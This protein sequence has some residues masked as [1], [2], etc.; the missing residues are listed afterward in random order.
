MGEQTHVEVGEEPSDE[1]TGKCPARN[2]V[3][4]DNSHTPHFEEQPEGMGVFYV[5]RCSTCGTVFETWDTEDEYLDEFGS[6]DGSNE[7]TA[8]FGD[9]F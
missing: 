4:H 8:D 1:P 7:H 2:A 6:E 3:G 5:W 9:V